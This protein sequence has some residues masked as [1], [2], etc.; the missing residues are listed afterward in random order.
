MKFFLKFPGNAAFSLT[1]YFYKLIRSG[2]GLVLYMI[3]CIISV[4]FT[5]TFSL[6]SELDQTSNDKCEGRVTFMGKRD[7]NSRYDQEK[8]FKTGDVD[9]KKTSSTYL[10]V[11]RKDIEAKAQTLGETL[12]KQAGIQVRNSGGTGSFSSISL[13]GS[14]SSQ[15]LIFMDGV[16]LSSASETG[17]DLGSIP[18]GDIEQVE[19]FK[20]FTPMNFG[21]A[22]MGG[23]VNIKTLRSKPGMSGLVTAGAGSFGTRSYTGYINH[24]PGI[25][26]Y[27]FSFDSLSSDNDYEIDNDNGT[28]FNPN[29]DRVEKRKN[30]QIRQD[31]LL[32]KT[33][34][35]IGDKYRI[36]FQ[37][38]FFDKNQGVPSYASYNDAEN[39][40]WLDTTRNIFSAS[41]TAN[42]VS[43]L[44]F[45][46]RT[47]FSHTLKREEYDDLGNT[48]GLGVQHSKYDTDSIEAGF[49]A[50]WKNV[51]HAVE[52]V[53]EARSENFKSRDLVAGKTAQDAERK[54]FVSGI[55]DRVIVD[56]LGRLSLIPG[57]RYTSTNDD[58]KSYTADGAG[59]ESEERYNFS[60]QLG[61]IYSFNDLVTLK[62]NIAKYYRDPTFFELFGDRGFFEGNDRL[63]PESGIN[64]DA[65]LEYRQK[66]V[67]EYVDE[68]FFGATY[69]HDRIYDLI[70]RTYDARGVGLSVNVP[71]AL[72]RGVEG[73]AGVRFFGRTGIYFSAV[74]QDPENLS[75]GL[76]GN[77]LP[78][79]FTSKYSLRAETGNDRWMSYAEYIGEN[80]MYYDT[81]NLLSAKDRRFINIG[82]EYGIGDIVACFDVNNITDGRYSDYRLYPS[83]GRSFLFTVK[84]RFSKDIL[85][86]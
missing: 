5:P 35:D 31:S 36:D 20:G 68:I 67:H 25:W 30:A 84:Y 45:S 10:V 55:Q 38:Q 15:V 37:D 4:L 85:D 19:V 39:D 77:K 51:S 44:L 82:A 52:F 59:F 6:S 13:R 86:N 7:P 46:T 81:P 23:A 54:V 40:A 1:L 57:I 65:G 8:N 72:V 42:D 83:P 71:G 56:S 41:F 2:R 33:G 78:G 50:E 16:P 14:E 18:L 26:D 24:K 53:T 9:L 66:C 43:P 11:D 34:C 28:P 62:S 32:A 48:I 27:L 12:D 29:D 58:G 74:F 79:R 76:K 47:R 63:V 3:F 60:P 70:T 21:M 73:I 80:D 69:F 22:S 17:V 75:D 49:Y 64:F 61:L